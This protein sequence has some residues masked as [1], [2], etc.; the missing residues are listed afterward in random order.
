MTTT[1]RDSCKSNK[2]CEMTYS[3]LLTTKCKLELHLGDEEESL[4]TCD[5]ILKLWA[6]IPKKHG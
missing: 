5:E 2:P 6:S 4:R 3:S 1:V